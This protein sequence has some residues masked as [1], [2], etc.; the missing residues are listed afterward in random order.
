MVP[1]IKSKLQVKARYQTYRVS[2]E[3][4]TS[5]NLYEVGV[6]YFFNKNMQLNLEYA[7]VNDRTQDRHNYNL[8]DVQLDFRF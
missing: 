3:W 6:N 2:K 4:D 8:V 7:Y 5:K 1:V